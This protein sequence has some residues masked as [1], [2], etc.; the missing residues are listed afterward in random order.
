VSEQWPKA[1]DSVLVRS[2]TPAFGDRA[3]REVAST[4]RSA[5]DT[6]PSG[7]PEPPAVFLPMSFGAIR[8]IDERASHLTRPIQPQRPERCHRGWCVAQRR[9]NGIE[10]DL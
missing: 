2:L 6:P 8:G 3:R 7:L 4:F 9:R 10:D 5:R 1:R